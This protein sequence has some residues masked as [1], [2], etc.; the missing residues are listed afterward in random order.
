MTR[1][2]APRVGAA[3][4]N[5]DHTRLGEELESVVAAGV[6]FLHVDLFDGRIVPDLAFPPRTIAA[7]RAATSLPF[8]VHLV[9]RGPEAWFDVVAST[10]ADTV[11]FH[12]EGAPMAYEA[13]RAARARGLR[14][15]VAAGL[16]TP[17]QVLEA[18]MPFVD[19]VLLL[20][21][22]TG[23]AATSPFDAAVLPRLER[24]RDALGDAPHTPEV[25]VAGGL[26]AASAMRVARAGADTVVLGSALFRAADRARL[27][28]ACRA[29]DE[30]VEAG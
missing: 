13:I 28:A 21:R 11:I 22:V 20:S 29:V 18:A 30:A 23:E 19:V 6:D 5:A 12:V 15:G 26:D 16:A 17:L 9:A 25:Q 7:L 1:D 10:G 14:V 27:V 8:E 4:F 24:L 2:V 3:V